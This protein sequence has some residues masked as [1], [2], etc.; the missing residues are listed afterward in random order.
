M[1]TKIS[2][3]TFVNA[4]DVVF[5]AENTKTQLTRQLLKKHKEEDTLLDCTKGK[6][7]KTVILTKNGLLIATSVQAET[8]ANRLNATMERRDN[9]DV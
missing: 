6:A 3:E 4:S 7:I 9:N 2:S 5:F 1:F 8:I